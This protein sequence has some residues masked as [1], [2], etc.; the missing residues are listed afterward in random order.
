MD[1]Y[2]TQKHDNNKAAYHAELLPC[3][4]EDKVGMLACENAVSVS[5]L[6]ARKPSRS[7]SK[8][9]LRRLPCDAPAVG[10]NGRVIGRYKALLLVI[11]EEICPQQ[12]DRRRN[13]RAARCKPIQ[14]Y[15]EYKEH[16]EEYG[17]QYKRASEVG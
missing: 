11:L 16:Y 4:R 12:R 14:L 7:K 13:S 15:A 10:V 2:Y 6:N 1:N 3:R 5:G 9:A 17:Q 8:L